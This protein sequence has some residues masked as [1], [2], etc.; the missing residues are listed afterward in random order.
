[1]I[2]FLNKDLMAQSQVSSAA[3]KLGK[4]LKSVSHLE[5]AVEMIAN[6]TVEALIVDLQTPGLAVE[7][8]ISQLN[9]LERRPTTIAFAQ[10]VQVGLLESAKSEMIDSLLTRGQFM[11]GIPKILSECSSTEA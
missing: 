3:K 1:M 7:A 10:H 8:L 4:A 5:K 9:H 11:N 6:E 2:V